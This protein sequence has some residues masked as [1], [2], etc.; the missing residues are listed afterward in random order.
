MLRR[1]TRGEVEKLDWIPWNEAI[2]LINLVAIRIW[3]LPY[4]AWMR[5]SGDPTMV[6]KRGEIKNE[7]AWAAIRDDMEASRLANPVVRFA[8]ALVGAVQ[9]AP[10][11]T[12]SE[13]VLFRRQCGPLALLVIRSLN[14]QIRQNEEQ[15]RRACS[16]PGLWPGPCRQA[17]WVA[18]GSACKG[19]S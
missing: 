11:H 4:I 15:V 19:G 17:R 13:Y 1:F 3:L 9:P 16:G 2:A 12:I 8:F 10:S 14:C 5:C 18:R 7:K 6:S